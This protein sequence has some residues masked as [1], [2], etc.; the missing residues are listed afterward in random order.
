[1]GVR[2]LLS[3]DEPAFLGLEKDFIELEVGAGNVDIVQCDSGGHAIEQL[4]A[5]D[6]KPFQMVITD[7]EMGRGPDGVDVAMEAVRRGIA[8]VYINTCFDFRRY[9]ETEK[10]RRLNQAA[11]NPNIRVK[12]KMDISAM[13]KDILPVIRS[14]LRSK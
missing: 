12:S 8:N 7:M 2:I 11:A 5:S 9:P 1:M 3:D 13:E 10:G 4:Q 6:A 14:L